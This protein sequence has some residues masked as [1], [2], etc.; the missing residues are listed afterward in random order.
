MIAEWQLNFLDSERHSKVECSRK[1]L[2]NHAWVKVMQL[3]QDMD[4][5]K[6]VAKLSE[7]VERRKTFSRPHWEIIVFGFH[8]VQRHLH[9]LLLKNDICSLFR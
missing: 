2:S 4:D 8:K 3:T 9:C 5:N 7:V 6:S 1:H